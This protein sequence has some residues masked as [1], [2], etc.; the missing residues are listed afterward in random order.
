M[1][2]D[3]LMRAENDFGRLEAIGFK[4]GQFFDQGRVIGA[5]IAKQIFDA[6]LIKPL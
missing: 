2:R 5:E 6:D 4:P 3:I 1:Y